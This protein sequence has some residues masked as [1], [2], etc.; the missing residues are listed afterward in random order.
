[1]FA[2]G[3]GG[4]SCFSHW[5]V[6]TIALAAVAPGEWL[7]DISVER[8]RDNAADLASEAGSSLLAVAL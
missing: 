2:L 6:W 8:R 7:K 1:M 4:N 5:G 3:V